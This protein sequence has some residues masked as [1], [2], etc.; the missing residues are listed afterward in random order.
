[1]A[2]PSYQS[3]SVAR[4]VVAG[5]AWYTQSPDWHESATKSVNAFIYT[6]YLIR[7]IGP[8]MKTSHEDVA[9]NQAMYK[10][11]YGRGGDGLHSSPSGLEVC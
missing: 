4:L 3:G 6:R 5:F 8:L 11:R 2:R 1:M 7:Y 10:S 9:S